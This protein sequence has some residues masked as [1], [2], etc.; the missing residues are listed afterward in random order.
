MP[1]EA[2]RDQAPVYWDTSAILSVL[3]ADEHT[4]AA[5]EQFARSSLKLVST[6]ALAEALAV[7][8]RLER[9]GEIRPKS[10]A[11]AATSLFAD[12]WIRWEGQPR[13]ELLAELASRTRLRGADLWHLGAALTAREELPELELLTFDRQVA[14]SATTVGLARPGD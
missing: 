14:T 7:L 3:V 2:P 11:R 5:R 4:R 6:L 13:R 1:A 10:R 9:E 12:P 8:A